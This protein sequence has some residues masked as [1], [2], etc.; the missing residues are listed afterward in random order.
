MWTPVPWS[1]LPS[2]PGAASAW[3]GWLLGGERCNGQ[4]VVYKCVLM[5]MKTWPLQ[6]C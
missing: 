5:C 6:I 4:R 2:R 1:A 3:N